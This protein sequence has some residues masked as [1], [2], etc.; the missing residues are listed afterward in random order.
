MEETE[1]L[2][3]VDAVLRGVAV[4]AGIVGV[5]VLLRPQIQRFAVPVQDL[6][7]GLLMGL[8]AVVAMTVPVPLEPG[9][10]VDLRIIPLLLAAPSSG[11]AAGTLAAAAAAAASV[12]WADGPLPGLSQVALSSGFGLVMA[13]RM[14]WRWTGRRQVVGFKLRHVAELAAFAPFAAML[15]ELHWGDLAAP[16]TPQYQANWLLHLVLLAGATFAVGAILAAYIRQ[17]SMEALMAT[18]RE[19]LATIAANIPGV[20]YRRGFGPDGGIEF[21]Y[22]SARAR[23]VLGLDPDA[24]I[25]DPQVFL[26][27]INT[28]DLAVVTQAIQLASARR[29]GPVISEFRVT[30]PDGSVVWIQARSQ[31]N[32][33]ASEQAGETLAEGLALDV[34]ARKHAELAA[35]QSRLEML[36]AQDH[37]PL[38]HLPNRRMLSRLCAGADMTGQGMLMRINLRDSSLVNELFGGAAGDLRIIE[39]GR[40]LT[41]A[42]PAGAT[43]AR[44]GGDEFAVVVPGGTAMPDPQ[45]LVGTLVEAVG[46]PYRLSGQ[47]VPMRLDLGYAIRTDAEVDPDRFIQMAGIAL[48]AARTRELPAAVV[49]TPQIQ[50]SRQQRRLFDQAIEAAIASEG[51]TIVWQPVVSA[52]G[53]RL[54]GREAL[55]RWPRPDV[56]EVG[57][58][59]F[60]PRVEAMG[61]WPKLDTF[62]LRRACRE[63]AAWP[64]KPWISVNM[65]PGWLAVGDLVGEVKVAL[66]DSGLDPSRLWLELTERALVEDAPKAAEEIR[67]LNALG[68]RVAIDDFGAAYSSLSYLDK[69]PVA[70]IKIDKSLIDDIE[71]SSRSRDIV[72]AI[73]D[74][75]GRLEVEVVAEGVETLEQFEWLAAIGCTAI[76]GYLT[77]RPAPVPPPVA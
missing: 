34:T 35:G 31:I 30:K 66:A 67:Q 53:R 17:M 22:M 32:P 64:E 2:Q 19:Q 14:G 74:L 10:L 44:M 4:L 69:L 50:E 71:A 60:V 1:F 55:V 65:S 16:I 49:F 12:L 68:V 25:A 42:A 46:A 41:E 58:G 21:R 15:P 27:R 72:T 40:R 26:S 45:R 59:V 9:H 62:V 52:P 5:M 6:V 75:C 8:L 36:W 28:D 7:N 3:T 23:E 37:D 61:L 38:T 33:V 70:K 56:G 13:W 18:A 73:V 29:S 76:Q 77:G 57:P 48:E 51:F 43:V 39:A 20:V 63:A 47:L 54:L 11:L 24:V